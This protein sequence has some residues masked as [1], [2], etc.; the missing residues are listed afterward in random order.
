MIYKISLLFFLLIMKIG[1]SQDIN[2]FNEKG[3][4][5]GLWRGYYEN[6]KNLKY[7]GIFEDGKEVGTFT[8]YDNLKEKTI[9]ATRTF[10]DLGHAYTTFFKGKFKVSE[11]LVVDKKYEGLWIT[12]HKESNIIMMKEN[13]K[14]GE[15]H[16][17][18]KS[19][20]SR[21]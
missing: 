3:N 14:N 18:K 21:W 6:T 7:E 5:Q 1:F 11:G 19:L 20:L 2:Q 12:Y 4:R 17:E 9:V 13:Y 8:F 16:G 15:L 10:N